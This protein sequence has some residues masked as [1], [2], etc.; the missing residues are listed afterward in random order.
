MLRKLFNEIFTNIKVLIISKKDI[1]L[2][3]L[4]GAVVH[5]LQSIMNTNF[6]I[7][8][9]GDFNV[10]GTSFL[11]SAFLFMIFDLTLNKIPFF[12]KYNKLTLAISF[13]VSTFVG[14]SISYTFKDNIQWW[15]W[16]VYVLMSIIFFSGLLVCMGIG[17]SFGKEKANEKMKKAAREYVQSLKE[18]PK[19]NRDLFIQMSNKALSLDDALLSFITM[20]DSKE[21]IKEMRDDLKT[22]SKNG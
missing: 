11:V 18:M 9:V 22:I 2:V 12:N 15:H 10:W 14:E 5:F 8:W 17:A 3:P 20:F 4:L 13:F 6:N 16:I 1:L 19:E 21:Q 7:T